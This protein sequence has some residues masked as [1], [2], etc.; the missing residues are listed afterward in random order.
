MGDLP[1]LTADNLALSYGRTVALA[2]ASATVRR[3]EVVAVRGPSGSGKSTMLQCMA[4]LV[5]PDSG[6]VTF[7][8]TEVTSLSGRMR[9]QL[10]L[11][12]FGFVFQNSELVP[13]LTLR[14]NVTL[15]LE[16]TGFP[17][18]RRARR[19][20]ELLD[21]LGI[22]REA[23]RRPA[24][25]SG[26]QAQRAAVARAVAHRPRVVF[27]DE[28][29]GAL[30]RENGTAVLDLLMELA[31]A[32]D[33]AVV[34]VTHDAIVAERADRTVEMCDGKTASAGVLRGMTGVAT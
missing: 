22:A 21:R 9:S 31:R 12:E 10:R 11:R 5:R 14:E 2:S 34:L 7:D 3:G 13:E 27:A 6:V 33:T 29:T 24:Q 19:V 25:V 8:G 16:L 17:R 23:D 4:G 18:A 26:G 30:D 15:P 20:A 28:P 1:V 32:D